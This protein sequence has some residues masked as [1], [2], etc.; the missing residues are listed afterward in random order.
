MPEPSTPEDAER[1]PLSD[2]PRTNATDGDESVSVFDEIRRERSQRG[3]GSWAKSLTLRVLGL[4]V[5]AGAC[6][7]IAR[8]VS[9]VDTLLIERASGTAAIEGKI[10]GDWRADEVTFVVDVETDYVAELERVLILPS[11]ALVFSESVATHRPLTLT[12]SVVSLFGGRGI[13]TTNLETPDDEIVRALRIEW[14][15]G[16]MRILREIDLLAL[17]P[18]LGFL[19]LASLCVVTRWWRLLALNQ[20][21]TSWYDAFRY[22]YSG[23]FFNAV[24]PGINGGDVARAVAVVRDHPD[25]RAD[26]FMTVV[27][28]RVLG[29][30]GMV[31]LGT[32]LVLATD[33]RLEPLKIPVAVFCVALL[34]G[35][36]LFFNTKVRR[37][38]G[39]DDLAQKLPQG[40]RLLR[41]DAGARR[42][43]EH[44][45][46]VV[47]A[48]VFSFGNHLFNGLA[49]FTAAKALGAALGFHDW[50]STMA[51]ANTLAAVPLSPGGLGVGEVLFGKLAELLGSTYAIGVATSLVY[52]LCLYVMSLLGGLVMLLPATK[53]PG[54]RVPG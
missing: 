21:A 38:I 31:V 54:E 22:T 33:A 34:V 45:R 11:T 42:L 52:R 4:L 12:D 26:A 43:I 40:E 46:E 29:L 3:K 53:R 48:L 50:L 18:A 13:V 27:V 14:R 41:L 17:L 1:E 39:F 47:L 35:I 6:W 5:L 9:W 49:V 32:A 24:V 37:I 30:V 44:P 2:S 25:S 19:I 16:M 20:C 7:M 23:L 51:V 10:S 36:G 28:D 8:N 15:P